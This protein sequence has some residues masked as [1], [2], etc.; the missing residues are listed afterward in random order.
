[1]P[2]DTS[3]LLVIRARLEVGSSAPL[4]AEVRLTTDVSR[5]IEETLNLTDAE[6]VAAVVR[7][8]LLRMVV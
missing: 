8:W 6:S 2:I 5:G 1:M 4:R 3:G 7:T